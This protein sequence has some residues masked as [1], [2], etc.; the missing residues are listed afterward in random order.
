M[1]LERCQGAAAKG[2][3]RRD[4]SL[5]RCQGF[6]K[7]GQIRRDASLERCQGTTAEKANSRRAPRH[8]PAQ[9]GTPAARAS[10]PERKRKK[11][12]SS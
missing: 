4:V 5:E 8:A 1:S 3:V 9:A 12:V 10:R 7:K 11:L 2:Q 6:A